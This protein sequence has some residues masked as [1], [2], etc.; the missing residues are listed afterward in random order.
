MSVH[1][2]YP[3]KIPT[4][5]RT[6]FFESTDEQNRI[7]MAQD[8]E[9][10][11]LVPAD[12]FAYTYAISLKVGAE[13][14][15][16]IPY[17]DTRGRA[18]VD[19][20]GHPIMMR[21][22]LKY[23]EFSREQRYTQPNKEQLEK[24]GLPGYMP[25][26]H[27]KTIQLSGEELICAEGEKKTVAILKHLNLPAFGIGGCQLW[28]H[29]NGSGAIH[30]WIRE[31]LAERNIRRVTIVPDGDVYRYDISTAYGNFAHALELEGISVKILAVPGKI[32]DL[33]VQWG[34]AARDRFME[35]QSIDPKDLVQ[36]PA[37]LIRRY[38]LAFK[39]D[40][41]DRPIVHQHTSNIM[42]L[43]E[44]HDAFP[45]IWRNQDNN[46][47]MVGEE[48]A[49]PDSTEMDIANYFQHNL[50][51]DK[52][53]HRTIFSC[54]HALA[55]RNARS[56]FLEYVR[57]IR[58]D[59]RPRLETWLQDLWGVR[60]SAFVR[61]VGSKW[62]TS[63]CARL[64]KPGTK[65]D[66][67]MIVVGPQRTGKT[68]MPSIMFKGANLTLY[69][70]HNDKD[71]HMLLHSALC[72]GFDELDSFNR[73]E[74]SNL[75]AMVT[76]NE[77]SFRPPY[78]ASVE[79]F[80]RRF[81]LYGCGNRHDFLQHDA[82]GYRRYAVIEVSQLLD[83]GGL[84]RDRDQLWAEAWRRY[85]DGSCTYW[86]VEG[87]TQEA[88]K[89]VVANPLEERIEEFLFRKQ[90]DKTA[91]LSKQILFKMTELMAHLGME[92]ETTNSGKIKDIAAIL[93]GMGCDKPEKTSRHPDTG[94]VGRWWTWNPPVAPI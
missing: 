75:K 27:P 19:T 40:A 23:P 58:W 80:P 26:I 28:R 10:S 14:G 69:G 91:G 7:F 41:K 85:S 60:D 53:T 89:F 65:I 47:I 5:E 15:Y 81:T 29:P 74:S 55:K 72:V 38:G 68:T 20:A 2:L 92:N 86:E 77:D 70:E 82:S 62:L 83:F 24:L 79:V 52:V 34:A 18:L 17:F 50:G 30:P 57:N 66:W 63:A 6:Q 4:V 51:F 31:L 33:I 45:R 64:D 25:Y 1:A 61:E 49:Q 39:T 73:K 35:L 46:R 59:G 78:G 32:D 13:A 9:K 8:L 37:A 56:P 3:F 11:G 22:R 48:T 67:M 71:L 44:E 94:A 84:E 87:A 43:M 42:K 88:E 54:I 36:S 16:F 90:I 12:I 93:H 21:T 76:R